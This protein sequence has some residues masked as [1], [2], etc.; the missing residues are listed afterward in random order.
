MNVG[1]PRPFELNGRSFT[2]AIWKEPA[3]GRRDVRGVNVEGD[4][5]ADR[6]VHGGRDKAVYA[7]AVEDYVWW[8]RRL[9]YQPEPGTFGE[10]LTVR[11]LAVNDAMVG[12]RWRI[13]SVVLQVTQPRMPCFKL[14]VRM[15]D[16]SFPRAFAKAARWG[17]YFTILEPGDVGAG[18]PIEV[19]HRPDH[20]VSIALIGHI[21]H[22]AH[23]RAPEL[24]AAPTLPEK[25]RAW[26]M[27]ASSR[28]EGE[29]RLL[30][31][32]KVGIGPT[33]HDRDPLV[34]LGFVGSGHKCCHR[35][36]GAV[37]DGETVG[38]PYEV[39]GFDDRSIGD[40]HAG[41]PF[42]RGGER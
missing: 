3:S 33:E 30:Q 41:E 8:T 25:W 15:E 5:Q 7:Y 29:R 11:G 27:K 14:G 36:G 34:A 22:H 40:E 23:D 31:R 37:L 16:A 39:A 19:V 42:V 20:G 13:G 38:T 10:N 32:R 24:L 35:R 1:T 9:S 28:A 4:D 21:Y 17:A 6:E 2:S 18:D 26:V 12:E